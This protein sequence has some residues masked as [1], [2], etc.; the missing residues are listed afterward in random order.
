MVLSTRAISVYLSYF[1]IAILAI[2]SL[3][4]VITWSALPDSKLYPVKRGLEK[5][6]LKIASADFIAQSALRSKL[7]DRRYEEAS[8]LLAKS[9]SSQ[10]L[11]EF[12]SEVQTAT[13][14]ML[15][16]GQTARNAQFRQELENLINQLEIYNQE[17]EIKKQELIVATPKTTSVPQPKQTTITSP[18]ATSPVATS[19]QIQIKIV[20]QQV[21][22]PIYQESNQ[23]VVTQVNQTQEQIN[24]AL[25]ELRRLQEE[26]RQ[27][28]NQLQEKSQASP[29]SSPSIPAS[30]QPV[31]PEDTQ[32]N[33]PQEPHMGAAEAETIQEETPQE[34]QKTTIPQENTTE[35]KKD[36]TT[37]N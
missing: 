5:M 27:L 22:V 34:P 14:D 19:P 6:A 1:L 13:N 11:Q 26:Q 24:Q 9:S 37:D 4:I 20:T 35:D 16:E 8:Q 28:Q 10:G 7:I 30:P 12:N 3:L 29:A 33:N 18:V 32:A 36:M 21:Q 15:A 25:E 17:F 31:P 23:Q 2:P